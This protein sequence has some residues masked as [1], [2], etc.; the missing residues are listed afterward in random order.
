MLTRDNLLRERDKFTLRL[1]D[2]LNLET[3]GRTHRERADSNINLYL[4]E[5]VLTKTK[6]S[7]YEDAVKDYKE[8]ITLLRKANA[9]KHEAEAILAYGN[10][11][12]EHFLPLDKKARKDFT[13]S[14]MRAKVEYKK[15][16]DLTKEISY[17][18]CNF[19]ATL[20]QMNL[21]VR[22]RVWNTNTRPKRIVIFHSLGSPESHQFL[23]GVYYYAHRNLIEI[24]D[25]NYGRVPDSDEPEHFIG[26]RLLDASGVVFLCS[27][28]YDRDRS[29]VV[30]FEIMQTESLISDKN[31]P[32]KVFALDIGNSG[33]VKEL[34]EF[35]IIAK[36]KDFETKI[37]YFIKEL[38]DIYRCRKVRC[39]K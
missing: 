11:I 24:W 16:I 1:K 18:R 25:Y 12:K 26:D 30:K 7:Y 5:Y 35:S 36:R 13:D 34:K 19:F 6:S 21:E 2:D 28:N 32:I 4:T 14:D 33:L 37:M 38:K 10:A 39:N 22:N 29:K 9:N 20:E 8:S 3:R 31:D 17:L 27:T 15:C 23:N